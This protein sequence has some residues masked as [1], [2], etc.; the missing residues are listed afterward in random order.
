M[1]HNVDID[2]INQRLEEI[3]QRRA[4]IEAPIRKR[5]ETTKKLQRGLKGFNL[6]MTF[7]KKL[8]PQLIEEIQKKAQ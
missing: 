2:A 4:E 7:L 8:G 3:Q 5:A 1:E 6:G